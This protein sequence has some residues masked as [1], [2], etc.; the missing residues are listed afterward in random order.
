MANPDSDGFVRSFARGLR[1]IEAMG[2]TGQH[3]VASIAQDTQL[4]RT[5]AR[6]ILLTLC[7]LGY[8][9]AIADKGFRLTPKVLS[10]GVT[11][12]TSLPFWGHAQR[13]LETVCLQLRESCSVAVLQGNEVVFVLRIPSA[14]VMS[15]RLG[16]GSH[17]PVHATAPGRALLAHQ[18]AAFQEQYFA[19]TELTP[20]TARTVTDPQI[21]RQELVC[22]AQRGHAWVEGEF[23]MHVSGLSVPIRDEQHQVVAALSASLLAADYDRA[24]A[25]Q[26]VLPALRSAASQLSGLAPSFLAPVL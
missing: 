26:Q 5:V 4:P 18:S 6:R 7:E 9:T 15:L 21:L 3:T 17:L 25:E 2:R 16:M 10:L 22:I 12:L 8:A 11:Y 1:V 24:R 14:N 23:D 19:R 20:I 13:V